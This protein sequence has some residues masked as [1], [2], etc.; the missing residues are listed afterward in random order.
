MRLRRSTRPAAL[1]VAPMLL[2]LLSASLSVAADTKAADPPSAEEKVMMEKYEAAATPTEHHTHLMKLA[3]NW[4]ASVSVWH[5]P[6]APPEQ[7][8][9]TA[10]LVP[11]M[12]N[13]YLHEEFNGTAAGLPFHGA[14]LSGYDNVTGKHWSLWVDSMS[15]GPMNSWGNC[16]AGHRNIN[17]KGESPNPLTGRLE[18]FRAVTRMVDNDKV[19]YEM[20]NKGK[21]GNEFKSLEVVYERQK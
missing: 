1:V 10:T 13:R 21:D 4:K 2:A 17:S 20:Y 19:V 7:S 5:A 3:G 14:G 15:T 18:P 6:G 11:M 9:G 12:G 8:T 16:D